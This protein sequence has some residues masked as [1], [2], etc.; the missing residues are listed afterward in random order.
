MTPE[1]SRIG[2]RI[3]RIRKAQKRT[4]Q[5]VA[6]TCGFTKSLL[7]KIETGKVAPPVATLVKIAGALHVGVAT[8][9]EAQETIA[10]V[11]DHADAVNC[12]V[13]ATKVGYSVFPFAT[14]YHDKKMQPF[15]FVARKGE[16]EDHS[17]DHD[18]EEFIYVVDGAM[19]VRVGNRLFDLDAG[20][21]LY[22]N[23]SEPHG[24]TPVSDTVRYINIFV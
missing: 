23:A 7:S 15:L 2:V 19:R 4:L 9:I 16:V 18:G 8:L 24:I 22:F 11:H 3:R 1:E 10:A 6:D 13:V 20:D 12:H 17:V 21:G 14:D 5:D